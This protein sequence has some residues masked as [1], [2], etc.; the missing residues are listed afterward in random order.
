MTFSRVHAGMLAIVSIFTGLIA[1]VVGTEWASFPF[2]LTN[3]QT[4]AYILFGVLGV[5]FFLLSTRKW[6]FFRVFAGAILVLLAYLFI[7]ALQGD[8]LSKGGLPLTEM[9][10]GWLFLAIG[11]WLLLYTLLAKEKEEPSQISVL[12]DTIIGV[13][14]AFTLLSLWGLIVF[15]SFFPEKSGNSESLL[16]KNFGTGIK[17]TS[18]SGISLTESF[19]KI[20]Q[21]SFTRANDAIQFIWE[22]EAGTY[23]LFPAWKTVY[24]IPKFFA[25]NGKHTYIAMDDWLY[26]NGN[27]I[28]KS[29]DQ[30]E[31]I[32]EDIVIIEE[33]GIRFLMQNNDEMYHSGITIEKTT[34]TKWADAQIFAWWEKTGSGYRVKKNGDVIGFPVE[35]ILKINLSRS[36][37]DIMVLAKSLSGNLQ[38]I[39]NGKDIETI[40]DW[41]QTW[42]YQSNGSHSIYATEK[43]TIKTII[44]DWAP[45][46]KRFSEVREIF[47]E[48]SGNSYAYFAKPVGENS[49]CLF[50][51]YRWNICGLDGYMNPRLGADGGSI[52]Y[53]WL[54]DGKWKIYRNTTSIVENTGYTK[55]IISSD[56]FFVD[57]TNPKQ[58]LFIEK[59]S[60]GKYTLNKNGK[61]I[62]GSWDDIWLD[63]TFWYD[64]KI[65]MSLKDETGWRIAE[66]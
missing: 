57:T 4:I 19:A 66:F 51:R 12:F 5:C 33:S 47:L 41:Y 29:G 25:Q 54:K 31:K 6:G 10:W 20:Q 35:E 15:I 17:I 23:T 60:D 3:I 38:I 46:Q 28:T 63:V 34:L 45:L 53:A 8:V 48:K 52:I 43:D 32:G 30:V 39:K 42:S 22:K 44:Y 18:S 61:T 49:Y 1:P 24:T 27:K 59:Q 16:S 40:Q 36:G 56:Y 14:W 64:N 62:S 65:I 2:P 11:G 50:T 58:Y 9:K 7:A 13:V 55:N 37:Y 26:Q 21:L